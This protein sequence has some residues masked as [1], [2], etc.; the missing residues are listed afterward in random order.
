MKLEYAVSIVSFLNESRNREIH[1]FRDLHLYDIESLRA[2][3]IF[4]QEENY[5]AVC[6]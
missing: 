2:M 3:S 6:F 5:A 1:E 4:K